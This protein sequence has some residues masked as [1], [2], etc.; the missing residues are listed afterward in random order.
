MIFM[1]NLIYFILGLY[2]VSLVAK[3]LKEYYL[4]FRSTRTKEKSNLITKFFSKFK[5]TV[6]E[7]SNIFI[8]KHNK[9][10]QSEGNIES[11]QIVSSKEKR[12]LAFENAKYMC[13]ECGNIANLD[14]YNIINI[15]SDSDENLKVLCKKCSEEYFTKVDLHYD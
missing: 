14:V 11:N 5:G 15:S 4:K 1:F 8:L 6:S 2:F 9:K 12:H 7:K 10:D 13:E 3:V